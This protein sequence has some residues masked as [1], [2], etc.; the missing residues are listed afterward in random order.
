MKIKNKKQLL[1]YLDSLINEDNIYK[2]PRFSKI[3]KKSNFFNSRYKNLIKIIN[4]NKQSHFDE[5]LIDEILLTTY[6]SSPEIIY[7]INKLNEKMYKSNSNSH[8]KN[9]F[10]KKKK[11]FRNIHF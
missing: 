2:M 9:I 8:I 5:I 11:I 6:F 10:Y 3:G 4:K 7:K 1:N